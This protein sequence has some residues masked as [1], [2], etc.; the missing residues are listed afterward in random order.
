VDLGRGTAVESSSVKPLVSI[1][2]PAYNAQAWIAD[3]LRSALAQTW[4]PKEIIVVDDGSTDQTLAIARQF[5]SDSVRV[6]SQENLSAAAARNKAY[7]M[8]RGDYIQWL[9]SDDLLAPD[10][11]A[12][13]MEALG[14]T[15]N[16]RLLLSSAYGRFIFRYYRAKFV[17]TALWCD[18]TPAEWLARKMEHNIFMQTATWLVSREL[19]EAVGPWNTTL[20][21]DD[22]GEYFCRVLLASEGTRFVPEA[23]VY[24]RAP[25]PGSLGNIGGS[26]RK[27]EA[28]WRS[29]QLHI[30]Y[31]R[32]TRDSDKVR[33]ACLTYLQ[34]CL[35]YFYPER[36]DIVEEAEKLAS[37]L[38]GQ[39]KPPHL[40]WKYEWIRRFFGWKIA[41]DLGIRLPRLRWWFRKW[42]DNALFH[43]RSRLSPP[44]EPLPRGT[45][46]FGARRP[47]RTPKRRGRRP[48]H[49]QPSP[50][51]HRKQAQADSSLGSG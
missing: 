29:M 44:S 10:K 32:S 9:D 25:W 3:T 38:R 41:K 51:P 26:A 36:P 27:I 49:S 43:L 47:G 46:Q 50:V 45:V 20:L 8:C 2:I 7:S 33:K 16:P 6:V 5:E 35:I 18:L 40:G 19:S 24:Y 12:R 48:E 13:Q 42:W 23:K 28:H 17:P 4:E 39:L 30:K 11:I 31:L 22:D 14:P 1:L 37:E 15:R 21:G 34:T